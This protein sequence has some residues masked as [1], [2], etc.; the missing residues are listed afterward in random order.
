MGAV[1]VAFYR[2]GF[3]IKSRDECDN[4]VCFGI[5]DSQSFLYFFKVFFLKLIKKVFKNV[6]CHYYYSI[7]LIFAAKL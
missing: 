3:W 1:L 2:T 7:L 4:L 6:C 5:V